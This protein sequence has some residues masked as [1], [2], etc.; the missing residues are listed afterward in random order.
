M[1]RE[2]A[3]A[4]TEDFAPSAL[5][6]S[7]GRLAMWLFLSTEVMLF[8]GLLSA[9]LV[10]R[11]AAAPGTWPM[12]HDMGAQGW[13]AIANTMVLLA[14]S[15]T[16]GWAFAA[17]RL[18]NAAGVR[19]WIVAT[20]LLAILFLA[21]KGGEYY[22]KWK[23]GI[24]NWGGQPLLHERADL[25]YLAHLKSTLRA[26][27]A[28]TPVS[29]ANESTPLEPP[30]P[31][32]GSPW[33]GGLIEWTGQQVG[34]GVEPRLRQQA[35]TNT[36]LLVFPHRALGDVAQL[37]NEQVA[38]ASLWQ[39]LTQQQEADTAR[40]QALQQQIAAALREGEGSEPHI[41]PT[42]RE[43]WAAEAAAISQ[44]L[45]QRKLTLG[46][47]ADRIQLLESTRDQRREGMARSLGVRW[48]QVIPHGQSWSSLYLLF[49]GC[50]ALH[51]CG[52]IM[53]LVVCWPRRNPEWARAALGNLRLYWFFVDAVWIGILALFYW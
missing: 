14:S 42:T 44:Q 41:A 52:G 18:G 26:T 1:N 17:S 9:Y 5:P 53:A 51:L 3:V 45:T 48:P 12:P 49:T 40:L 43:Q 15:V 34:Q 16:L 8:A 32:T 6:I 35:L 13:I 19:G 25:H 30:A 46:P 38:L 23:H 29:A 37:E 10:F 2:G 7:N 39:E 24:F 33:W 31:P 22:D 36:A 20:A 27:A 47:L 4:T 21:I 11:L 50:H 28:R